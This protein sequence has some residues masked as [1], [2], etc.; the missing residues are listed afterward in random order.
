MKKLLLLL[1]FLP[2]L[3]SGQRLF[4]APIQFGKNA[5]TGAPS[6]QGTRFYM[7]TVTNRTYTWNPGLGWVKLGQG[8]DI[9]IGSIPPAYTPA[10]GQSDFA[11]NAADELYHYDGSS[12]VCLNCGGGSGIDTSGY[13]L[14]FGVSG[15]NLRIRDGAG[16][17][18]VPVATIAPD[19]SSTN[20]LQRID[21]FS[22]NG[23]DLRLSISGDA[24]AYKTVNLSGFANTPIPAGEIAWGDG[25]GTGI[26]STPGLFRDPSTGW[27]GISNAPITPTALLNVVGAQ[28]NLLNIKR[29]DAGTLRFL[30]E[31]ASGNVEQHF[32]RTSTV[33][34]VFGLDAADGN[35]FKFSPVDDAFASAKLTM[36]T[37][38]LVGI[39]TT[40]PDL[41]LTVLGSDPSNAGLSLGNS[42]G[43]NPAR[44]FHLIAG[45]E[46]LTND[47][48]TIYD[49]YAAST[50]FR[51]TNAGR[52]EVPGI[53][54]IGSV[55]GITPTTLIGRDGNG[56]IGTVGFSSGFSIV[57]GNITYTP[58]TSG[59][60]TNFS[61]G[62]LSPLFTTS[63]ATTTTTPALSFSLNTQTANTVFAGPT[64]G[65]AAAPT[66]RALVAA[67]I[68]ALSYD[69]SSTNELQNLSL[70]GQALGISSGAGV[71]LPV[72]NITASTGISVSPSAGNFTITNTGDTDASDDHTG[73]GINGQVTFW[74]GTSSQSGNNNLFWDNSNGRLG[75]GTTTPNLPLDVRGNGTITGTLGVGITTT[76]AKLHSVGSGAT[77]ST[78]NFRTTN[79]SGTVGINSRDDGAVSI[80]SSVPQSGFTLTT[81]G[82]AYFS[83]DAQVAGLAAG[84]TA[85]TLWGRDATGFLVPITFNPA[86]ITLSGNVLDVTG[87]NPVVS[88]GNNVNVTT[89]TPGGITTY[90]IDQGTESVAWTA[91]ITVS[92]I[93]AQVDNWNP[94]GWGTTGTGS[95]SEISFTLTG[96]QNLTGVAGG[97]DGRWLILNNFDSVD[98]LTLKNQNAG[99]SGA[100]RFAIVSDFAI[101]PGTS[102]TC[103][104]NSVKGSWLLLSYSRRNSTASGTVKITTFTASGT[105]TKDANAV[106]VETI[107]IAAG[108]GGGSGRK[109]ASG[110]IRRGGSGGG[111]GGLSKYTFQAA[112]LGSTVAV[113]V[114]T[115]GTGAASQTTNSTDGTAGSAGAASSFGVHLKAN[116]GLGGPAGTATG[117]NGVA[118]GLGNM[119][120]SVIS[121]GS[122]AAGDGAASTNPAHAPSSGGGGGSLPADNS[123]HKGGDGG[124]AQLLGVMLNGV[125]ALGAAG[126][127]GTSETAS[128][129]G[130]GGGGGSSENAG[131]AYK[132]GDGGL[133]GA[134]GGGGGASQDG[135]GNSG[136]G[137]NG[138]DGIV[139]VIEYLSN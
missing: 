75:I 100:N 97:S 102:A 106:T 79:S 123:E 87:A 118:S 119:S 12:W 126:T 114:G 11:L 71:T 57:S 84:K 2:S 69:P 113:T 56:D 20:E 43:T 40:T 24:Q 125:G 103:K 61:A 101:P 132:G 95:A 35:K 111:A 48:F 44:R 25:P 96:N 124:S 116:G 131:A 10:K 38:G 74:T 93:S 80:G 98:T 33:D 85:N 55:S 36:T 86:H 7:D 135:G 78:H 30:Y 41:R 28:G 73:S 139:I 112:D 65:G 63:E 99:S 107:V 90:L 91:D 117:N 4:T 82:A 58:A 81:V 137:G 16:I 49:T 14:A 45:D 39:G 94:T 127:D 104:Y 29:T 105:W 17:L 52:V 27:V 134:G 128:K 138:A 59:T 77:S 42:L 37:G 9:I 70:S 19:Q 72:V 136:A 66:F 32:L 13:N 50:R 53:F 110:T 120:I 92:S 51:I 83:S 115:G 54:R 23:N 67:D 15:G 68:P 21:T 89:S 122:N 46:G 64:T 60:V 34:W 1:I 108:A 109:G 18:S 133:Y 47:N 8:V 88:E 6:A 31:A 26:T 76:S 121:G 62:D 22:L 5:I 129:L 130:G 3:L